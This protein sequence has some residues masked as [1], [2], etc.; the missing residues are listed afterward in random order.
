[1]GVEPLVAV[2]RQPDDHEEALYR[3]AD[4][5]GPHWSQVSGGVRARA[6]YSGI[7]AYVA[8]D[9]AAEGAVRHSGTHGPH[10]HSIKVV[11]IRKRTPKS[12]FALL[13]GVAGPKPERTNK[14]EIL[15]RIMANGPVLAREAV[16]RAEAQGVSSQ[17]RARAR[18]AAGIQTRWIDGAWWWVTVESRP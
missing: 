2:R 17:S 3:L 10:P 16:R 13:A 12:V 11:V 6:P 18:R 7:Y 14:A 1:M 15:R 8:C 5:R 9:R 4:L